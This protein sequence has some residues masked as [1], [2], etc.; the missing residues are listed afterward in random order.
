MIFVYGMEAALRLT[1]SKKGKSILTTLQQAKLSTTNLEW[2]NIGG[3]LIPTKNVAGLLSKIKSGAIKSWDQVHT[4]YEAESAQYNTKKDLHALTC[5]AQLTGKSIDKITTTQFITW[6]NEYFEIK[7]DITARIQNTRA[8]D[9]SNP[10]RKMVY[11][12]EAEM[13]AVVGSLKDN[14]FILEQ[15]KALRNLEKQLM[16]IKKELKLQ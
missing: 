5:L 2:S 12:N 13:N 11:E 1:E 14:S 16:A 7:K 4:F 9:Y 10:F 6:I 3:Q 15:N 8:K